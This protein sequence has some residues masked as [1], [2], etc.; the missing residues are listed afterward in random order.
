MNLDCQIEFQKE[1]YKVW[2]DKHPIDTQTI[3][4]KLLATVRG[5]KGYGDPRTE[6]SIPW[7]REI[8]LPTIELDNWDVTQNTGKITRHGQPEL[9]SYKDPKA[10]HEELQARM[11]RPRTPLP[12]PKPTLPT[13]QVVMNYDERKRLE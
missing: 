8:A 4:S 3:P 12:Q 9:L 7:G 2:A 5:K 6:D 13:P 11:K 1:A 10:G